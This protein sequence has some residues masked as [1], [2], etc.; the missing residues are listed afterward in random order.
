MAKAL[1]S[2]NGQNESVAYNLQCL[3]ATFKDRRYEF[4]CFPESTVSFM[5]SQALRRCTLKWRD[6]RGYTWL[7]PG[8]HSVAFAPAVAYLFLVRPP[9]S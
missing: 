2:K 4:R 6:Q 5:R 1:H 7:D 8:L 9:R 3:E